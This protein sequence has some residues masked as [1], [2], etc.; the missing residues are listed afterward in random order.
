MA[1]V[2]PVDGERPVAVVHQEVLLDVGAAAALHPQVHVSVVVDV[3]RRG[4]LDVQIGGVRRGQRWRPLLVLAPHRVGQRLGVLESAAR[5]AEEQL[6]RI[7]VPAALRPD[8]DAGIEH[9]E[10]ETAVVVE[11]VRD[12]DR[13][14]GP[15]RW[16]QH[17][18]RRQLE[19]PASGPE[20]HLHRQLVESVFDRLAAV[21]RLTARDDV[22]PAVPVQ[23][24]HGD[25]DLDP[26]EAA[27]GLDARERLCMGGAG[28]AAGDEHRDDSLLPHVELP[29]RS[30][31]MKMRDSSGS[32]R[33][34]SAFR[35]ASNARTF[36][37]GVGESRTEQTSP[38]IVEPFGP[39]IRPSSRRESSR[40]RPS[41][42]P[43]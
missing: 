7:A 27:L 29:G 41:S 25:D 13:R 17:S 24:R 35:C 3:A 43:A 39:Q 26:V 6:R 37:T 16:R 32:S 20:E 15:D 31:S 19:L 34:A 18:R 11:V 30:R 5:R 40:L 12:R 10:V 1:A 21:V 36:T 28:E 42:A 4:R 22:V 8:V 33:L 38:D 14:A 2:V 23:V 9:R